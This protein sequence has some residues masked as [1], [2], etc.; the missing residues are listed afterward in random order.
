M[1]LTGIETKL[2]DSG[3]NALFN[4]FTDSSYVSNYAKTGV[5]ACIKNE[6]VIGKAAASI[7]PTDNVTRAETAVMIQ[8]LL[9]KSGLI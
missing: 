5:A 3:L 8:R 4:K 7:A 2:S 6:I 9:Q 1:E